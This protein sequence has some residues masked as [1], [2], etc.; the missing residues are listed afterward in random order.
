MLTQKLLDQ[1]A[2]AAT[3]SAAALEA[4]RMALHAVEEKTSVSDKLGWGGSVW[5]QPAAELGAIA[6]LSLLIGMHP[7][8][9]LLTL[10]VCALLQALDWFFVRYF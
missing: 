2:T 8:L 6:G 4:M 9:C 1:V 10:A 7:S 5:L 3:M